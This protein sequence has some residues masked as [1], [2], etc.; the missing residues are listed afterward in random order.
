MA[1]ALVAG[2]TACSSSSSLVPG[3]QLVIGESYVAS[4]INSDVAS[5]AASEAVNAEIANLT[6]ASFYSVDSTGALAPNLDFGTV[7]VVSQKP[8][9]V[10][11]LL[12]D[13]AV[14]SDG[15]KVS[16]ADLLLSWA[17]ATNQGG[18]NFRSARLGNG[19]S[20]TVGVPK[21]GD[22]NKSLTI[23]FSRPVA[24]YKT[25][26]KVAVP[27]HTLAQL[28]FAGDNL[29]A[30]QADARVVSAIQNLQSTDLAALAKAYRFGYQLKADFKFT[31]QRAVASGAY[32]ITDASSAGVTL[33][34]NS[35][36]G[37]MA[38]A[39]AETVKLVFYSS[40][41]SMVADLKAGKLDLATLAPSSTESN[42]SIAD[43]LKAGGSS[44][45]A[46]LQATNTVEALVFNQNPGSS[47]AASSFGIATKPAAIAKALSARTAFMNLVSTS[48]VQ[49]LVGATQTIQDAKSFV[50]EPSSSFYQ[51]TIQD[52]GVLAYQFADDQKAYNTIHKLGSRVAV[53]VLFDTDNPR[54]QI[55]YSVLAE[56]ASQVGF[57]LENVGVSD[58]TPALVSGEYDVFLAPT[59]LIGS[60]TLSLEEAFGKNS[61]TANDTAV[62]GL[63]SEFATAT[64]AVSQA[65][66]LK[67]LDA[68]LIASG[69]GLPLYQLPLTV[70]SSKKLAKTP[71]LVG[72][73]SLTAGYATWNLAA[74]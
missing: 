22:G 40:A 30:S 5:S 66:A 36:N 39:R 17:A 26:I 19:L 43:A 3:S 51:A 61:P 6:T 52:S 31:P 67:K 24:D 12:T 7:E 14:F 44:V 42:S 4:S 28:A 55:E 65:A 1:G 64:D 56:K 46:S 8:F 37:A 58:P 10:K 9:T 18:A 41:L 38:P 47:F 59:Q 50:F 57:G 69:Y 21:I 74:K 62:Q 33:K 71:D 20:Q 45:S 27:A 72:G 70:A 49:T 35:K 73:S 25:A 15:Q 16:A 2:L 23:T 54:A 63:L 32:V 13:K 11:Y 68:S 60:P 34:A 53:R 48:K 29:E